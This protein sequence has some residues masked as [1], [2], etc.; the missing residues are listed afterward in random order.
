[1]RTS[2]VI[3]LPFDTVLGGVAT[4][5]RS[6]PPTSHAAAAAITPKLRPLQLRVLALFVEAGPMTQHAL[7][8]RYRDRHG[9]AR[10]STVRT[11]CSELVRLRLLADTGARVRL[12][13]GRSAVRWGVS[14]AGV[15]AFRLLSAG[16]A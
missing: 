15:T 2:V 7:I 11:R 3:T 1:M 4:A 12:P 5:R 6:D 13:N 16:G 14:T 10:E 8:D 9:A